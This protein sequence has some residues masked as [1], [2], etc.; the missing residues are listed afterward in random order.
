[1][2]K[3][4]ESSQEVT[5]PQEECAF[6]GKTSRDSYVFTPWLKDTDGRNWCGCEQGKE[7]GVLARLEDRLRSREAAWAAQTPVY[8]PRRP[9]PKCGND[10]R[11]TKYSDGYGLRY[12]LFA[13]ARLAW[14]YMERFCG[15][16]EYVT[17]EV[18]LD[19]KGREGQ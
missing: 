5:V 1:M 2:R 14:P 18:P 6:C 11:T 10:T 3:S 4:K 7:A 12:T 13:T 19:S 17:E 16:C 15:R 9:C 8:D